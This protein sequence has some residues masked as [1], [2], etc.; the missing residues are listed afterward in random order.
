LKKRYGSP[1]F[2]VSLKPDRDAYADKGG[3]YIHPHM[4]GIVQWNNAA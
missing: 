1:N 3:F 4:A 2:L